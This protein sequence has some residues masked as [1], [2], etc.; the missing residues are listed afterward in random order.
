MHRVLRGLPVVA[1]VAE[2]AADRRIVRRPLVDVPGRVAGGSIDHVGRFVNDHRGL[3]IGTPRRAVE[4]GRHFDVR[5]EPFDIGRGDISLHIDG[6][7]RL[8]GRLGDQLEFGGVADDAE[9]GAEVRADRRDE[10]RIRDRVE[11]LD[12][13]MRRILLRGVQ[14]QFEMLVEGVLDEC[15]RGRLRRREFAGLF[16]RSK[17]DIMDPAIWF[18]RPRSGASFRSGI[19]TAAEA[20]KRIARLL[21][22]ERTL[23]AQRR[24]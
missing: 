17:I 8:G 7:I 12:V 4:G 3:A 11:D 21:Y 16:V 19:P 20:D 5:A 13:G 2:L 18:R 23:G 9:N 24:R 6:A 1:G 15:Q 22:P 14:D 10:N